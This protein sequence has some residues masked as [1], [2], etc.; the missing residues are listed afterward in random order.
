MDAIH[1]CCTW[2]YNSCPLFLSH[3]NI[4]PRI[5]YCNDCRHRH[6]IILLFTSSMAYTRMLSVRNGECSQNRYAI[7]LTK[8]SRHVKVMT[9]R[10]SRQSKSDVNRK[11]SPLGTDDQLSQWIFT[12]TT[13]RNHGLD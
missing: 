3:Q 2:S 1:S 6:H 5:D 9:D 13:H 8:V 10:D 7:K 12:F 11:M 4:K